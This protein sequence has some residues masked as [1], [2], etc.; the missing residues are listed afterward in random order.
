MSRIFFIFFISLHFSCLG[1]SQ[2]G[3]GVFKFLDLPASSRLSAMGGNNVSMNDNDINLAFQNPSLLSSE[4]H[5]VLSLNGANYLGDIQF[6]SVA[7][8]RNFGNN[9]YFALG[10]Q[11]VDYGTFKQ[12][13]E[14]NEV[15]GQF[16]AMDMALNIMYARPLNE[17]ISVGA[18]LKP[19]YSV[20][21]LYTSI[22]IACDLGLN[23][24]DTAGFFSAGLTFRNIGTQ[25]KGYYS[26][27]GQQHYED[28]P[29]DIL[30]GF[31]KKLKHA[32]LR[33]HLTLNNLNQWDLKYQSTNQSRATLNN[34]EVKEEISFVDLAFRHSI[35]AVEF[36]P[37]KNFYLTAGYNHRRHQELKM[38]GFKS[39]AG[40]S[41]GAG[42]KLYKFHLGFSSSQFQVGNTSYQFSISTALNEFRL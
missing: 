2:A 21:E 27:E 42:I 39:T 14:L 38:P 1:F 22:G 20:Y 37:T 23:Y 6:G 16:T 8:G 9:N 31:S 3:N 26:F 36:V 7:Y 19:I 11:Y 41:F 15:I 30:I 32:P 5:N 17:K 13:T 18:T 10:M 40:F 29:F 4:T 35:F 33:F 24:T 25:L 12:V 28:L 34:D